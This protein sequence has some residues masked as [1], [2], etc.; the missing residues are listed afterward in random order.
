MAWVGSCSSLSTAPPTGITYTLAHSRSPPSMVQTE[1][2]FVWN[3]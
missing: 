1:D 3:K 2:T